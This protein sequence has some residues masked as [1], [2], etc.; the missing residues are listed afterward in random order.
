MWR[1][2]QQT[3]TPGD[4]RDLGA[5]RGRQRG[6]RTVTGNGGRCRHLARG[7]GTSG[8]GWSV[9]GVGD[10]YVGGSLHW[11]RRWGAG[12]KIVVISH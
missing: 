5:G 9:A 1:D 6:S 3:N 4:D 12:E 8:G 7:S 2:L 11:E 10:V